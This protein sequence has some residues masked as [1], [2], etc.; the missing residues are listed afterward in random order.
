MNEPEPTSRK[1]QRH[2]MRAL[3]P[4]VWWA[5]FVLLL[6]AYHTHERLSEQ[7]RINF[8]VDLEGKPVGYEASATLDGRRLTSGEQVSLGTH[9]FAVSHQKAES[10]ST[11]LF[12]WYGE[13]DLGAISLK[14][15]RGILALEAKP[16]VTR[17][18]IVGAE[19][20]MTFTNCTGVTSSIPTDVYRVDAHWANHDETKQVTV[21][22]GTM[23]SLRLA[24]PLGAVT[25]ESNPS[26]AM[27]TGSEG[28]TLGTTPLTLPELRTGVWKGELRLEGYIPVPVTL[29]ITASETNSFRTNLVNWQY[30]Q[31]L[32][33]ARTYFV[34]GDSERALEAISA[35]LKAK[36]N[37]PDALA[38]QEKAAVLQKQAT[39]AGHLRRAEEMMEAKN[40]SGVMS[41]ANAVLKLVPENERALAL[42]NEL[43]IREK[44]ALKRAQEK[45]EAQRQERLALPKKTFDSVIRRNPDAPL[46]EEHELQAGLPV[47]QVEAAIR[48]ELETAPAFKMIRIMVSAPEAFAMSAWQDVP[49][50]S[51]RCVIAGAQTGDKETHVFFKVMEYKSK[52]SVT[53]Q[54]QLTITK[55]FIPLDPSRIGELTE[56]EKTQLKE[57]TATVEERLR[58][59]IRRK[60][61]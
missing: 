44:E 52:S 39:V 61:P 57:G 43:A 3:R 8:R 31:A 49:E 26:G 28:S 27:V 33:S 36:P 17:L 13:R 19:F 23:S 50:G 56:R 58:R 15:T 55:S 16:P 21:T 40:Y 20:S 48:Q 6:F 32:E 47:T 30:S 53:F 60:S 35:A 38:L 24:P 41:E 29:S 4:L 7:T 10:F 37:D 22:S 18:S 2:W 1:R 9:Q 14:R 46:F 59:A 42:L 5:V 34:A 54:G 25:L 51:R 11:N 12:I 45:A